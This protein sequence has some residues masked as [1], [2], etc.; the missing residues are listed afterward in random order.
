MSY[1]IIYFSFLKDIEWE[2]EH[3][4]DLTV[5]YHSLSLFRSIGYSMVVNGYVF[6]NKFEIDLNHLTTLINGKANE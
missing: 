4:L 1:S 3:G 2:L 5:A 6:V